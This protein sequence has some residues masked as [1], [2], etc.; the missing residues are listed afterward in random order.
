MNK[1]ESP[2]PKKNHC[3]VQ[4]GF[5]VLQKKSKILK[6]NKDGRQTYAW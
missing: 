2:L 1:S 4:F 6:N 3:S 5:A